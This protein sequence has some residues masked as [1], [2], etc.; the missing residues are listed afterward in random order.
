MKNSDCNVR[1]IF[2]KK[3]EDDILFLLNNSEP[4]GTH[5]IG[6]DRECNVWSEYEC[7]AIFEASLIELHKELSKPDQMNAS[8]FEAAFLDFVTASANLH[9]TVFNLSRKSRLEIKCKN[10]KN[11]CVCVKQ[12]K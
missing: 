10:K 5:L 9:A 6:I 11:V 3:L 7:R 2:E 1:A 8:H 4:I 12:L